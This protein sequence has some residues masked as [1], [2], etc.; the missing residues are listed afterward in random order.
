MGI[1]FLLDGTIPGGDPST[2]IETASGVLG[3]VQNVF[4]IIGVAIMI[5]TIW[6]AIRHFL[7][8][9][10]A[11]LVKTLVFGGIAAILCFNIQYGVDIINAGGNLVSNVI[12][13]VTDTLGSEGGT[14][15]PTGVPTD[16]VP[17]PPK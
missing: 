6:N 7:S 4:T 12:S 15:G 14:S 11:D 3:I 9:D 5:F 8:Q 17:V 1:Y 16:P 10:I 2:A 13:T